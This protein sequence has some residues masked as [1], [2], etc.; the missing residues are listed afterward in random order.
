MNFNNGNIYDF[1]VIYDDVNIIN[2]GGPVS[3]AP[4]KGLNLT[5]TISY[6]IY[7]VVRAKAWHLPSL[8]VNVRR[9]Y[10]STDGKFKATG[11]LYAQDGVWAENRLP[12]DFFLPV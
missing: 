6:N 4:L 11:Q 5:S 9:F 3:A 8:E 12:D 7:D 10:T 1:N 2:I